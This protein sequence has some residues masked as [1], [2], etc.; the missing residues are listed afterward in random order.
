ML[1]ESVCVRVCARARIVE[2]QFLTNLYY[3]VAAQTRRRAK[4]VQIVS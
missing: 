4:T 3:D 1:V 2:I